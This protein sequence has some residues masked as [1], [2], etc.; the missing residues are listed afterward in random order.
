MDRYWWGG[1][2]DKRK[3]HRCKWSKIDQPKYDG[4]MG[5]RDVEMFNYC[6]AWQARLAALLP[7]QT[8]SELE[9]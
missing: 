9:S 2:G 6:N 1:D 4:G 3:M 7:T 8:L 5:F